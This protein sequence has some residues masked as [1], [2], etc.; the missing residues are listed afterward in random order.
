MSGD[1]FRFLLDK[2]DDSGKLQKID[3]KGYAGEEFAGAHRVGHFGYAYNPPKGSHGVGYSPRGMG[4][5]AF[6]L[7]MEHPDLRPKD[8]A[9]GECRLYDAEGNT[10]FMGLKNGIHIS[11]KQ[12]H[13]VVTSAGNVYLNG[14]GG[15]R[16]MTENGPSEKVYA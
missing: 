8:L 3:G 16:V 5:L 6:M 12:G 9:P 10:I 2:V 4:D 1:I 14:K 7:G 13:V 11:N 15:A